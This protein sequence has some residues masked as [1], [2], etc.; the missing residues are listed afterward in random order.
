MK[1]TLSPLLTVGL[2]IVVLLNLVNRFVTPLSDWV[3]IPLALLAIVLIIVGGL[4]S[5]SEIT[6]TKE[7][8]N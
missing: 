6:E 3:A 4:K 8:N 7:S 5:K 1:K 2:L